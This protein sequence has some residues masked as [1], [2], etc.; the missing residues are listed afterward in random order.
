M[1]KT[2]VQ[3]D[4][5]KEMQTTQLYEKMFKIDDLQLETQGKRTLK[6][7]PKSLTTVQIGEAGPG[8]HC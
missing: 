5:G 8:R 3:T 4:M 1:R 6:Y 7:H 2:Y